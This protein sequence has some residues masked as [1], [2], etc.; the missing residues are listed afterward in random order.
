MQIGGGYDPS[1]LNGLQLG[2]LGTGNLSSCLVADVIAYNVLLAP[3][4]RIMIEGYYAQVRRMITSGRHI[5]THLLRSLLQKFAQQS[6]LPPSHFYYQPPAV[7]RT[8]SP[9]TT[10]SATPSPSLTTLPSK[11]AKAGTPTTAS[12]GG[13]PSST[14]AQT[15]GAGGTFSSTASS[16]PTPGLPIASVTLTLIFAPV[17]PTVL[18]SGSTALFQLRLDLAAFASDS[19]E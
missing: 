19:S 3:Y 13:T 5:V 17:S 7:T 16:S 12:V 4:Q 1:T 18:K 9:S 10:P 8:P 6:S 14:P 15:R 11:A 2:G